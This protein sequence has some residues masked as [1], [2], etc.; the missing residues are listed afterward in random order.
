MDKNRV[1][2]RV[3]L[4]GSLALL[5]SGCSSTWGPTISPIAAKPRV[6][7]RYRRREVP[8]NGSE[9]PGTIVVD[10][11][12]RY[13]YYVEGGGSAIRYGIGVGEEGRTLKGRVR[14]GR[15]AEW[16]SWTPTE[17]MMRRKPH[18]RQYAGGVSGGLHN[19]LGAS[20]LYLYRGAE[21]TMFRLHGTNEPWTIGQAVSSGCIRLT[22][23]DIVDL[24]DRAPVG[25]TV[26]IV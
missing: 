4:L 5:G 24:Y 10:T 22:N 1:T 8:Y 19:P 14:V 26:L 18:L 15:K 23:E 11:V 7:P 2:R 9:P 3:L 20:A 17:N 6:D 13:L 21:D 12:E 25:T 16:P